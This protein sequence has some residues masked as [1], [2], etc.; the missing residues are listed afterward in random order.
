MPHDLADRRKPGALGASVIL[1]VDWVP[2]DWIPVKLAPV[3]RVNQ[4]VWA[5]E[6]ILHPLPILN[7]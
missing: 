7:P 6:Q 4:E 5:S 2:V 1:A 3:L